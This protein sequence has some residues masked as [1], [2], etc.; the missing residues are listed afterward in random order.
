MTST[1]SPESVV[2]KDGS[3]A[4]QVVGGDWPDP[5]EL[6]LTPAPP[7]FPLEEA[8]PPAIAPIRDFVV[9]LAEAVQVPVDVTA[10]Q[11]LPIASVCIAHKLEVQTASNHTEIGSIYSLCLLESGNRKS[12]AVKRMIA[13][14]LQWELEEAERAKPQIALQEERRKIDEARLQTLRKRAA[15]DSGDTATKAKKEAEELAQRLANETILTTPQLITT[16]PTPEK[17]AMIMKN[18]HER[19][20]IAS[21]EADALDVMLG[22]YSKGGT[23]NLGIF[24][25]GH[26]GDFV[27]QDRVGRAPIHLE[28]PALSIALTVQPEAV[29]QLFANPQARGRGAVAR[30]LK[31]VPVS[32]LGKRKIDPDQLPDELVKTYDA[33]LRRLLNETIPNKPTIITLDVD[34]S[35]HFREF[36]TWIESELGKG[37]GL[38]SHK[39]WAGKL[40]GAIA[41]I[42]LAFHGLKWGLTGTCA[43]AIDGPTMRAALAWSPYLIDHE[44]IAAGIVGTDPVVTIAGRVLEWLLHNPPSPDVLDVFSRRDCFSAC[45]SEAIQRV[46]DIDPALL[47]LCDLG[48][49]RQ[50]EGPDRPGPGRKPSEQY[51]VNP[52]WRERGR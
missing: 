11:L 17:L 5:T 40:A 15:N 24:L 14:L 7:P 44:R 49:L 28:S 16:E 43:P 9:G 36:C 29:T 31:C 21:A 20:L 4:P 32:L 12:S 27:K 47:L 38:H 37:G 23:P 35:L 8:F 1:N 30:F 6:R 51:A 48:Y 19:T 45:R 50:V 41:R 18:N 22:R 26:S 52:R 10:M 46:V 3:A 34:A 2:T 42:A 33:V 25:A 13:P 39:E